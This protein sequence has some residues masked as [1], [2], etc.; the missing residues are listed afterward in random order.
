MNK[1]Y[2]FLI[3]IPVIA[4]IFLK[5]MAFYEFDT[6]QRYIKNIVDNVAH[7]VMITGVMTESDKGELIEKLQKLSN[8]NEEDISLK[9][10]KIQSDG[11]LSNLD[12][13]V[14]GNILD[15]G[16]I[17][18]IYVE[19]K[20]GSTISIMEGNTADVNKKLFYKAK[21]ICRIE[22]CWQED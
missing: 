7:K 12:P 16:E 3:I 17:F 8:F 19:S 18:S 20:D 9:C 2:A 13:Y 14:P 4:L 10:G 5:T 1:I 11:S 21:A 22:K 15:R 6:K